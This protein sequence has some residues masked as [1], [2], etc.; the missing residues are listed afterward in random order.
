MLEM[1]LNDVLSI[2]RGTFLSGDWMGL[3]IAFGSVIIA[4]VIM[5]RGAQIGSMTLLALV[6]FALGGYLRGVLSGPASTP[7]GATV[8]GGRMVGQLEASWGAFMG[9]TA[10][11]LLAYFV[12]FMILILLVFGAKTLLSRG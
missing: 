6:L 7:D 1:I 3:A 9:L 10:A 5:R 2:I 12:A 8:T 4:A 11:T